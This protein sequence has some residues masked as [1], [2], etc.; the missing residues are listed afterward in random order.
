L[1][2]AKSGRMHES[3]LA[4]AFFFFGDPP[5]LPNKKVLLT[6]FELQRLPWKNGEK[7]ICTDL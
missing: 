4:V 7:Y 2:V 6:I 3:E 5:R 1:D